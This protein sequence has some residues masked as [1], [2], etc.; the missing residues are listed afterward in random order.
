MMMFSFL[1]LILVLVSFWGESMAQVE[2]GAR[3]VWTR[4]RSDCRSPRC[5]MH[6][7][8]EVQKC[9]VLR[10]GTAH[11]PCCLVDEAEVERWQ[12]EPDVLQLEA[13]V[14]PKVLMQ[15]GTWLKCPARP[16]SGV[17]GA[18]LASSSVSV[19]FGGFAYVEIRVTSPSTGIYPEMRFR[20]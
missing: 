6:Q 8:H 1:S 17:A 5:R 13:Y 15:P 20:G 9:P 3:V 14:R 2:G 18:H 7:P 11:A 4:A 12:L 19:A 10:A 16:R